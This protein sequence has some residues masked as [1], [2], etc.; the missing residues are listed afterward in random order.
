MD[1]GY[2]R[3][4]TRH[5]DKCIDVYGASTDDGANV[6]QWSCHDNDNQRWELT[7]LSGLKSMSVPTGISGEETSDNISV[8]PNPLSGDILNINTDADAISICN[9]NGQVVY[10]EDDVS[11]GQLD[12]GDIPEGIYIIKIN[13]GDDVSS[14]KLIKE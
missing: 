9:A 13:S 11:V 8:Y 1:D 6:I 5:C 2:Y 10:Q 14:I 7:Y 3:I 4:R 12:L